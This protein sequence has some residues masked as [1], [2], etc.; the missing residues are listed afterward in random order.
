MS[1]S[2]EIILNMKPNSEN[3][4]NPMFDFTILLES[5]GLNLNRLQV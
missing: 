4:K 3:Y 5:V 1:L 2:T